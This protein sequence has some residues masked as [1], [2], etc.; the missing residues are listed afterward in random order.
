M[1][2]GVQT[3]EVTLVK[4]QRFEAALE[5]LRALAAIRVEGSGHHRG[6][7]GERWTVARILLTLLEQRAVTTGRLSLVQ[8]ERPDFKLQLDTKGIGVEITRAISPN[9]ANAFKNHQG[10][11]GLSH[12]EL[13]P[14]APPQR[15]R[16]L[17]PT[18][19]GLGPGWLGDAVE[20]DWLCGIEIGIND[21]SGKTWDGDFDE[22]WLFIYEDLG[23]MAVNHDEVLEPMS[24]LGRGGFDRVAVLTSG[25]VVDHGS[26]GV[27][28]LTTPDFEADETC[29]S[30]EGD[31][32]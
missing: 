28:L 8:R 27:R 11:F 24:R 6:R 14:G 29:S 19:E 13:R 12:P 7:L 17:E 23:L 20:R 30:P 21:K 3:D 4:D 31:D 5:D 25:H 15:W 2:G 22:R 9:L 26:Q 18:L 32:G 1:D 16:D 10:M